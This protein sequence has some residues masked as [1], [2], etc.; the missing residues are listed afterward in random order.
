MRRVT[1]ELH[2]ARFRIKSSV[3]RNRQLR[4]PTGP[5]VFGGRRWAILVCRICTVSERESRPPKR[6]SE[7]QRFEVGELVFSALIVRRDSEVEGGLHEDE[8]DC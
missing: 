3:C 6:P 5:R 1:P 2:S 8:D 4:T 7:H